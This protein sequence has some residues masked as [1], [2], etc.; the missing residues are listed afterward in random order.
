M[1]ERDG[2]RSCAGGR[3]VLV[4]TESLGPSSGDARPRDRAI[5][6]D[7]SQG[8]PRTGTSGHA[9]DDRPSASWE[10]EGVFA[11]AEPAAKLV[12]QL[13]AAPG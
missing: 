12:A 6:D 9:S 2:L 5:A 4:P 10:A 3:L 7:A 1:E 8:L 11:Q 13:G